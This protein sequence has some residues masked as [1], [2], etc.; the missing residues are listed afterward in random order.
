MLDRVLIWLDE[1]I[2][3]IFWHSVLFALISGILYYLYITM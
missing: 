3:D 1:N 2:S